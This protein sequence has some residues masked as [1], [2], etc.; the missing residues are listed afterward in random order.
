MAL[1]QLSQCTAVH[2]V[3]L[4]HLNMHFALLRYRAWLGFTWGSFIHRGCEV[5]EQ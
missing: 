5:L 4:N 1:T 3:A 2:S